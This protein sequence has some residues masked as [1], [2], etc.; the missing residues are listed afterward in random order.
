MPNE[1]DS[2]MNVFAAF[3]LF[4]VSILFLHSFVHINPSCL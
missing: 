1:L 4:I 3:T 2:A